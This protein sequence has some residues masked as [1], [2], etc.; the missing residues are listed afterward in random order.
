MPSRLQVAF[1]CTG[2]RFRSPL[3]AALLEQAVGHD[4]ADITSAGI[5]DLRDVPAF[6]EAI[7]EGERL[8]VDL[9]SHRARHIGHLDLSS[10]DLVLGFE[11]IHV[12]TAVVD[13]GA[14][15][16]RSFTLPE[17]AELLD[18]DEAGA[19]EAIARAS[20]RRGADRS[21]RN[22]PEVAD[23]AGR[24]RDAFRQA[25]DEIDEL[26]RKLALDLFS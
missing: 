10:A 13:A 3:A 18:R 26:V 16:S 11:Q 24:G 4:R 17:L 5:L 21:T 20:A 14:Q 6:P 15:R 22:P 8:G 25:A 7:E 2:N 23:P 9:S 19:R 12:A 1:V